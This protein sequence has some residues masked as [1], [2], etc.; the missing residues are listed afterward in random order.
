M[1]QSSVWW[2]HPWP[3]LTKSMPI[4]PF[5]P[6]RPTD[7]FSWK[8]TQTWEKRCS[9]YW[10][11]NGFGWAPAFLFGFGNRLFWQKFHADWKA[12]FVSD[13]LHF[14][15]PLAWLGD[16]AKWVNWPTKGFHIGD[17]A[18]KK[19]MKLRQVLFTLMTLYQRFWLSVKTTLALARVFTQ[20]SKLGRFVGD[21]RR[22][23]CCR[24]AKEQPK[25]SD[26]NQ[27]YYRQ[28]PPKECFIVEI[29]NK[30]GSIGLFV[31]FGVKD[32]APVR[33]S[34]SLHSWAFEGTKSLWGP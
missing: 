9:W 2:V 18:S 28:A 32:D 33:N 26:R 24:E 20:A 27:S 11:W 14:H 8:V 5:F 17:A 16:W 23:R 19:A 12:G 15:A 21:L 6:A 29:K 22:L 3:N 31:F 1:T 25:R 10:L 30:F 4:L 34:S 7:L 13:A